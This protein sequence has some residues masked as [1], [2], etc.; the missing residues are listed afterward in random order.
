[1]A[2]RVPEE[3]FLPRWRGS[4]ESDAGL[5]DARIA[6]MRLGIA[7][8][9]LWPAALAAESGGLVYVKRGS[10]EASR[11]ASLRATARKMKPRPFR[12]GPWRIVGPFDSD[13]D[14]SGFS[15]RKSMLTLMPSTRK[16]EADRFAGER[17]PI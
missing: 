13:G 14:P 11:Q 9:L 6:V 3:R 8:L 12:Q 2:G 16:K 15:R 17:R 10:H 1:M 4:A 5:A 7:A